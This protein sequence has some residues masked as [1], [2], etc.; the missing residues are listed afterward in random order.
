MQSER[1]LH[2]VEQSTSKISPE[3]KT[4]IETPEEILATGAVS[5]E[6]IALELSEQGLIFEGVRERLSSGMFGPIYRVEAKK[7]EGETVMMIEKVFAPG[8]KTKAKRFSKYKSDAE[9]FE[10][11]ATDTRPRLGLVDMSKETGALKEVLIDWLYNEEKALSNLG[12][13]PGIPKS[14]GAVYEGTRGSL[15]EQFVEGYD[16]FELA[17]QAQSSQEIHEV[18]DRYIM[19]YKQ[20]AERGYIYNDPYGS[21][22]MVEQSTR[23]PY[24][25]D[26]YKHAAGSIKAEGPA[27]EKYERG[28]KEIELFRSDVLAQFEE[29]QSGEVRQ[30][31]GV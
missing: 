22:V 25:I 1:K 15:L 9:S 24:L 12:D 27:K 18:F 23:Q 16:L 13:I 5:H 4:S 28:L 17:Q 31:I 21:T 26:W 20:A 30:T 29:R 3:G 6:A 7:S 8:D 11:A 10:M 14:Y 19:T 2:F